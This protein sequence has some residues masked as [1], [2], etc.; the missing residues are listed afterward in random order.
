MATVNT[1]AQCV[2]GLTYI[3]GVVPQVG[4]ALEACGF[5]V[6]LQ[7]GVV[8]VVGGKGQTFIATQHQGAIRCQY[9]ECAQG[10]ATGKCIAVRSH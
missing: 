4:S 1:L 5:H 3:Q 8:S 10:G 6:L 7:L 9:M 2:V